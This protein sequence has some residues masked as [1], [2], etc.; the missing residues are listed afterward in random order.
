[1][2]SQIKYTST[3][4]EPLKIITP[5]VD[6]LMLEERQVI[7]HSYHFSVGFFDRIRIHPNTC[8]IDLD[9]SYRSPMLQNFNISLAPD[10]TWME[11]GRR[12]EFTLVFAGLP[13]DCTRFDM[14]EDVPDTGRLHIRNIQRSKSDVYYLRMDFD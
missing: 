6:L 3:L 9:T 7:L 12:F 13:K 11:L 2:S 4:A 10:W 5:D 14:L 1:M 8:L